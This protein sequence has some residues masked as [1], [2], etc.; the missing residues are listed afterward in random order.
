[1]KPART[2]HEAASRPIAAPDIRDAQ[3]SEAP[4][5]S[6]RPPLLRTR[7]QLLSAKAIGDALSNVTPRLIEVDMQEM[8]VATGND[9]LHTRHMQDCCAL[10]LCTDRHPVTG[11]YAQRAL[12]HVL[13]ACN[14]G[15]DGLKYVDEMIAMA[16]N[17][18]RGARFVLC[19]GA[20][21]VSSFS[22][23]LI[24]NNGCPAANGEKRYPLRELHAVC[25]SFFIVQADEIQV[26]PTGDL[27]TRGVPPGRWHPSDT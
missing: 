10:I 12:F 26:T 8:K 22:C 17:A 1:M 14:F 27:Y 5:P 15:G 21:P 3:H 4:I 2:V 25:D 6:P 23:T 24:M 18:T 16:R 13:G 7:A 9:Y 11:V 20:V 19:F